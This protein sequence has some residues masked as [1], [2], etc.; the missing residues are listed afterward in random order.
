MTGAAYAAGRAE[1]ATKGCCAQPSPFESVA[2]LSQNYK[3]IN[4]IN[5]LINS[6]RRAAMSDTER[7]LA[8]VSRQRYPGFPLETS[9][10][11][12]LNP[13]FM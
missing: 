13:P 1:P 7:K 6:H 9:A 5:N 12:R 10:V 2:E 4:K 11:Q 3:N 8:V